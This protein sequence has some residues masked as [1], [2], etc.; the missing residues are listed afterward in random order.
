MIK[1]KE[2]RLYPTEFYLHAY[3]IGDRDNH[4]KIS[5]K[6]RRALSL[7]FCK[8]YGGDFESHYEQLNDTDFVIKVHP[9]EK[10]ESNGH[11]KIVTVLSPNLNTLVHEVIHILWYIGDTANLDMCYKSQEWQALLAEYIFKELRYFSKIPE[12]KN[13]DKKTH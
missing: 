3:I 4:G 8:K 5:D 9:T 12:L 6:H 1:F 11:I 10:S 7:I 2:I 13:Y